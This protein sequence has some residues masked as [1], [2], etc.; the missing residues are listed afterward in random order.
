MILPSKH[1]LPDRA[2]LSIG[3][4]ILTWAKTPRTVSNLWDELRKER[5][6]GTLRTPVSYDWFILALDLLFLLG[7]IEYKRGLIVVAKS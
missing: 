2:L 4:D 1:I 3:A 5:G 7:A 6:E